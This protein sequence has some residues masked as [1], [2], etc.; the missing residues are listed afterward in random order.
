MVRYKYVRPE[1]IALYLALACNAIQIISWWNTSQKKRY[2]S[3][4]DFA[5]IKEGQRTI[6]GAIQQLEKEINN[7]QQTI[8][9]GMKDTESH[10]VDESKELKGIINALVVRMS[11][12]SISDILS[13]RKND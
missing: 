12:D 3:E 7:H 11:G 1:T 10:I 5:S 2:A 6:L 4:L 13:R 9:R 8:Y